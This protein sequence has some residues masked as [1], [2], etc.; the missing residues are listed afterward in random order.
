L[1]TTA[2]LGARAKRRKWGELAVDWARLG[3][4]GLKLT[5]HR[6]GLATIEGVH[7]DLAS[8]GADA[9]PT[10]LGACRPGAVTRD[11]A[12]NGT[13][14][15]GAD[16]RHEQSGALSTTVEWLGGD[17]TEA[18]LERT[19]TSGGALAPASPFGNLA[20][21]RDMHAVV[22][23]CEVAGVLSGFTFGAGK[24]TEARLEGARR[25]MHALGAAVFFS[26]GT[27][28][29][30]GTVGFVGVTVGRAGLGPAAAVPASRTSSARCAAS[31]AHGS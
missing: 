1:A 18:F 23:T 28:G 8:L 16:L 20:V 21:D 15:Y 4:A 11:H 9:R 5:Q 26:V 10:T 13:T 7:L 27:S 31:H 3:V 2:G 14:S 30:F 19:A 17:G 24:A 6:A 25:A 22:L 12:V 29:T